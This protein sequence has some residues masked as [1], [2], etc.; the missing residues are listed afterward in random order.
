MSK[1][2]ACGAATTAQTRVCACALGGAC[3]VLHAKNRMVVMEHDIPGGGGGGGGA[4]GAKRAKLSSPACRTQTIRRADWRVP[5]DVRDAS[6]PSSGIARVCGV[7]LERRDAGAQLRF[8]L[9]TRCAWDVDGQRFVPSVTRGFAQTLLRTLKTGAWECMTPIPAHETIFELGGEYNEVVRATFAP[10]A[11][12]VA[13]VREQSCR[14]A[15]AVADLHHVQAGA[16]NGVLAEATRVRLTRG[17]LGV[18]CAASDVRRVVRVEFHQFRCRRGWTLRVQRTWTADTQADVDRIARYT[19]GRWAVGVRAPIADTL[20]SH[21][22]YL[23][24]CAL[25]RVKRVVA[26]SCEGRRRGTEC[27]DVRVSPI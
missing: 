22:P 13:S 2:H 20:A 8:W 18:A 26:A 3:A 19:E 5:E 23:A 16:P 7:A 17:K 11:P 24:S 15:Y 6:V 27:V 1:V 25:L 4:G 10:V 9:G 21:A 12:F 14:N